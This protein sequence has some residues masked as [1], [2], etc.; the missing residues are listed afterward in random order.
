[1]VFL[2]ICF[3][4]ISI[5]SMTP[6]RSSPWYQRR[7]VLFCFDGS[8]RFCCESQ[9]A[10][11]DQIHVA[12]PVSYS[13][14]LLSRPTCWHKLVPDVATQFYWQCLSLG[15]QCLVWD[16]AQIL[17][18]LVEVLNMDDGTKHKAQT[19]GC[20]LMSSCLLD[21]SWCWCTDMLLLTIKSYLR[22]KAAGNCLLPAGNCCIDA[23]E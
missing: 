16:K 2:P 23:T 7:T 12:G 17:E 8:K 18:T 10:A 9:F 13:G 3:S 1:M 14:T 4:I 5:T 21:V 11:A 20:T 15:A 6:T 22:Q 19:N